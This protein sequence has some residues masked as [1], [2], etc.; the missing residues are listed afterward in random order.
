MQCKNM[1]DGIL[2]PSQVKSALR[3]FAGSSLKKVSEYQVVG[4]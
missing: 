2:L 3:Y 1:D 4:E